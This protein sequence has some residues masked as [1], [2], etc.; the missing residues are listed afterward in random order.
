[1]VARNMRRDIYCGECDKSCMRTFADM[2]TARS[3]AIN[4][5]AE[6]CVT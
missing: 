1:M 5:T 4:A 3:M 6:I 2:V